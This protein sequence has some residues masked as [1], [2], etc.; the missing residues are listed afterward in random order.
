MLD[1]EVTPNHLHFVRNN[2]HIPERAKTRN[3]ENWALRID[4][5]LARSRSF[6]LQALQHEFKNH[7]SQITIECA[8]NGRAGYYPNASGNQW[9]LGAVGCAQYRGVRLVDVLNSL[10]VR[11]T[12]VYIG[13]YGEDPHLSRDPNKSPISRSVPIDKALDPQTLLVWEMNGKPLPAEH[14]FPLRLVCPG[15]PGSTC[16]KWLNRIWVRD[17]IHDGTKMTGSSY[18][19]PRHPV[20]P[21]DK[22]A[23]S[24]MA[25]I[26]VMPVKS[27][28]TLPKTG[29][30]IAQ[31]TPIEI[32][33]HAWIGSGNIERVDVTYDFGATWQTTKLENPKNKYA[34]QRWSA[35]I[36]LPKRDIMKS[37]LEPLTSKEEAS[38]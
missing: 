9:T 31:A 2:G 23:E 6:S 3:L 13:Y 28:I 8:G 4:G 10:G 37:G 15:W 18:R 16:G 21:G 38:P 29:V 11:Q 5:E 36:H 20:A 17:K 14:G 1:D 34:W 30:S 27:M 35:S 19:T 24:D 32:R 12:A 25:I 7:E 22:V 33:G 26:T